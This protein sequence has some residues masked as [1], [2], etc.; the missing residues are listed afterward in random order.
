MNKIGVPK[1]ATQQKKSPSKAS[2][3]IVIWDDPLEKRNVQQINRQKRNKFNEYVSKKHLTQDATKEL[4]FRTEILPHR[5]SYQELQELLGYEFANLKLLEIALT[6]KSSITES[7]NGSDYERLEFLGDAVF[8]LVTAFLLSEQ[9]PRA[10]EGELS[11][12]RAAV[13]NREALAG[14]AKK[15]ELGSYLKI[16]TELS[17]LLEN[18]KLLCN[19]I[20]SVVGAVFCDSG[21][22]K[23]FDV[24]RSLVVPLLTNISSHDPKTDFQEAAFKAGLSHPEYLLDRMEGSQNAPIFLSVIKVDGEV[25]AQGR[26]SSKKQSHQE[27]ALLALKMLQP[28][29]KEFF[30]DSES[31]FFVAS[32]FLLE[33]MV[34]STQVLKENVE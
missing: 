13:I 18:S 34:V 14:V 25:V 31:H 11:K 20:E 4:S 23:A 33:N 12:M 26:G 9:Y 32:A 30:I 8:G 10:T 19:I 24:V 6:H 21:Y 16:S 2:P 27:A 28:P 15:L 5:T 29:Y 1:I 7:E 17:H 3:N 22:E